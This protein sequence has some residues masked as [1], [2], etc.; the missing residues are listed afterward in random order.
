MAK[1][2]KKSARGRAQDRAKV[3]G[4]QDYAVRYEAKKDR[5]SASAVKAVKKVVKKV[6]NSLKKVRKALSR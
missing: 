6:G 5:K 4:G 1:K 2:A 3:A